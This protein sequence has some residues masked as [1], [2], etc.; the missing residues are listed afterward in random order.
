MIYH[1]DI[2]II[3]EEV[4][5]T[6]HLWRGARYSSFM[7]RCKILFIY[8]EVQGTLDFIVNEEVESLGVAISLFFDFPWNQ[9]KW[10]TNRIYELKGLPVALYN[11]HSSSLEE[12]KQM[13]QV[14]VFLRG[15][16]I[17]EVTFLPLMFKVLSWLFHNQDVLMINQEYL[18][19]HDTSSFVKRY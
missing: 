6:F 8:E 11:K 9:E 15:E 18:V 14:N 13:N 12:N 17:N 19:P 10:K 1:E 3:Y 7:K 16:Q 4:Q 5:G 2:L